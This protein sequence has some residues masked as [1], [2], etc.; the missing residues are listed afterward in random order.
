MRV[1][2]PL[3]GVM[4]PGEDPLEGQAFRDAIVDL[5]T[6]STRA[7]GDDEPRLLA[8]RTSTGATRPRWS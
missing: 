3:F 1:W 7:F 5:V 2:K 4:E 8:P 6:S